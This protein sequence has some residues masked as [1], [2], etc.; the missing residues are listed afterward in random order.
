MQLQMKES[1]GWQEG[2][3]EEQE[4]YILPMGTEEG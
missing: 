4:E 2:Q 3:D 1:K